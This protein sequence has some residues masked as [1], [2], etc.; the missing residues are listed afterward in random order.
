MNQKQIIVGGIALLAVIVVAGMFF[1]P[2]GFISG[3]FDATHEVACMQL[4]DG[5]ELCDGES[6]FWKENTWNSQMMCEDAIDPGNGFRKSCSHY[7]C[8]C[9]DI[10]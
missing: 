4:V 8:K 6:N 9:K 10:G 1:S 5:N 2:S 7:E 3:K